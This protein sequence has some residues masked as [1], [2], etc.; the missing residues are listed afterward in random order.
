VQWDKG[1]GRVECRELW[2]VDGGEMTAYLG[3]ELHWPG[4]HLCGRIRRSRRTIGARTWEEQ[5]THTWVT[6]LSRERATAEEI[7]RALRGHWT[8][9]NGVFRV[10]DVSYDEDRL[11]GRKI[12]SALSSL[13]N[14]AINIFRQSRYPFIPDGWRDVASQPDHGI[15]LLRAF[16]LI[17]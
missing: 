4:L 6:S 7:A 14:I 11:H 2:V 1:H 15:Q 9:E 17:L 13:R 8:V 16:G 10:R 3:E 12:A 5:Q